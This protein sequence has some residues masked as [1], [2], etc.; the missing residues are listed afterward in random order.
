MKR[1]ILVALLVL[2]CLTSCEQIEL[3]KTDGSTDG[4]SNQS[5]N[6]TA[7]LRTGEGTMEAPYTVDEL[8]TAGLDEGTI[9][10]VIGYAVGT[11]YSGMSHAVFLPPF[12]HNSNILLA[13]K[14]DC[15]NTA[16]C[17]PVKLNNDK[18]KTGLSLKSDESRYQQCVM[19]HGSVGRYLSTI[20]I[21][22]IVTNSEYYW[23]EGFII[24]M[25]KPSEWETDTIHY[26]ID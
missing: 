16:E 8:R 1:C 21:T 5:A 23:F 7:P 19:I 4:N 14:L 18:T 3:A 17:V 22:S 26:S 10:W 2:A 13:S 25:S 9:V 11:A 20:G 24:P 15:T 6:I 12:E